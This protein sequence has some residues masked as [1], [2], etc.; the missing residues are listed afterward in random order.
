[1]VMKSAVHENIIY[2]QNKNCAVPMILLRYFVTSLILS[3]AFTIL[4]Y[5]HEKIEK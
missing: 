1:M 3:P 4:V 2:H 5:F